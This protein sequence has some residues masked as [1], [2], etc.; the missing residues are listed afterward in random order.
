VRIAPLIFIPFVEN[1]FKF[2]SHDDTRPNSI[3]INLQQTGNRII[4]QC[5]NSYE[6]HVQAPGGIGLVNVKRRLELLYRDRFILDIRN[7]TN[8]WHVELILIT[9]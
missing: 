6:E 1:A 4:F 5:V 9:Q 8:N 3:R 7:E 2:S